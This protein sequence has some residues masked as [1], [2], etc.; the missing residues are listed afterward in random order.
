MKISD[1]FIL[2]QQIEKLLTEEIDNNLLKEFSDMTHDYE[3]FFKDHHLI[4]DLIE[5]RKHYINLSEKISTTYKF[6]ETVNKP[7]EQSNFLFRVFNHATGYS[8]F[9][10]IDQINQKLV[11]LK[12]EIGEF[13]KST[14]I[15]YDK[16]KNEFEKQE[17]SILSIPNSLGPTICADDDRNHRKLV[18]QKDIE[19]QVGSKIKSF[20]DWKYPTVEIGPGDGRWTNNL[21]GSDPL[22]LVDI[23]KEYFDIVKQKYPKKFRDR[24]QSYLIGKENNK[25]FFDLS[26][27]P[28]NQIGFIFSWGVFDFYNY[29]EVN[30]FLNN[31]QEILRPGGVLTFSYNDC[32]YISGIKLFEENQKTWLTKNLLATLFEKHKL[33]TPE[34]ECNKEQDTFW[35]TVRKEGKKRSIKASQPFTTIQKRNGYERF[36]SRQPIK[37]NKQQIARIKQ[38]AIGLGVDTQEKIMKDGYDPHVLMEL[39]NI[40][41]MKK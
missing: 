37:Y 35:V 22:Y 4:P 7:I 12:V 13:K 24:I 21:V 32:D 38:L 40:A 10:Q 19:E 36:D 17:Q 33:I 18:V 14:S 2:K 6:I 26:G 15:F 29:N 28:S 16:V 30:S 39:V 5:L 34:F 3:Y 31:C 41:R 9:D 23:H 1:I 25:S 8:V 20:T 11:D 27:L